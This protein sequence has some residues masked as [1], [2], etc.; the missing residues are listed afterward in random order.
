VLRALAWIGLCAA[1]AAAQESRPWLEE[2]R[3]AG[4]WLASVALETEHGLAWQAHPAGGGAPSTSLYAGAP[5]VVLLLYELERADPDG[6]WGALA[7]RGADDLLARLPE[8]CVPGA[9]GLYTGAAGVGF[10]LL[11]AGRLGGAERH[12]AGARRCAEFLHEQALKTAAGARLSDV[13]DVIA[14][15]AGAGFFLLVSARELA[16]PADKEL[17]LRLGRELVTRATKTEHGLDWAMTSTYERR[18]PNFSHGTAGVACFLAALRSAGGEEALLEAARAGAAHLLATANEDGGGFKLAHHTPGGEEL[19]YYSWCHGPP[20]TARLFRALGRA[21]G[22]ESWALLERRCA[23]AVEEARLLEQRPAGFWNTVGRCCGN[24]GVAELFLDLAQARGGE[25]DLAVALAFARDVLAR[26]TRGDGKVSWVQAEHRVRPD[27][28]QA[29]TGL[30]QGAAGIGLLFLRLD[31]HE[32]GRD[33][34]LRM[35]EDRL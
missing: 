19:F 20:G 3:G 24:V 18:M 5:G 27:L 12:R 17:A 34:V 13:T 4:R 14:G 23:A 32:R 11:E 8:V 31:A 16:R 25:H 7:E 22:D 26:A 33:D 2:A 21:T 6:E 15:D 1:P 28:L 30:M 29:Q 9:T 10:A 35:P